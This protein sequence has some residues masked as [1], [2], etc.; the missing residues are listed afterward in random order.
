MK[1]MEIFTNDKLLEKNRIPY[2]NQNITRYLIVIVE[3][4]W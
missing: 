4:E 1:M 3:L 2:A